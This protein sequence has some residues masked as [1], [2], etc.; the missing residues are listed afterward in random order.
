MVNVT[1]EGRL[2]RANPPKTLAV[3]ASTA[4]NNLHRLAFSLAGGC[5]GVAG[6]TAPAAGVQGGTPGRGA[7]HSPKPPRQPC[8][9]PGSDCPTP[10]P[11]PSCLRAALWDMSLAAAVDGAR[12]HP[13]LAFTAAAQAAVAVF[14]IASVTAAAIWMLPVQPGTAEAK[15]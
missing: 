4:G 9:A 11:F 14:T 6:P 1:V 3:Y 8:K 2:Q 12:V 7:L 5:A 15:A 10:C 13:A